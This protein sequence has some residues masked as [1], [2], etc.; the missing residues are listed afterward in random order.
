MNKSIAYIVTS[1]VL[2][3]GVVS[4]PAHAATTYRVHYTML[5]A[6]AAPTHRKVV[7]LPV[8]VEVAELSAGGITEVVPKW[9][10]DAKKHVAN[11]LA[12]YIRDNSDLEVVQSL[13]LTKAQKEIAEEHVALYKQV[14]FAAQQTTSPVGGK[15]WQHKLRKFDYTLGTG[16][17]FLTNTGADTAVLVY[18]EDYISTGGRQA[19]FIAAAAAG[20]S[21]QLGH[22][23]LHIG[24]V[25]LKTGNLL[26]TNYLYNTTTDMRKA[27][28]NNTLVK[29]I[30]APYPGVEKY[31]ATYLSTPQ[32]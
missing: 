29:K 12:N 7:V 6:N 25:D 30:L 17:S 2:V 10:E 24:V 16:L 4:S 32:P 5:E 18:G 21:I 9:S 11:A 26:W 1:V 15:G 19:L 13:P 28:D 27:D 20:V 8:E 31:R 14:A 23:F 3:L 22:T